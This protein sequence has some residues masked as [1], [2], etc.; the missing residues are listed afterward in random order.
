MSEL[1]QQFLQLVQERKALGQQRH[2][3]SYLTGPSL[4]PVMTEEAADA[5]NYAL[6][7][8]ARV[9]RVDPH[10]DFQGLSALAGALALFGERLTGTTAAATGR[11]EAFADLAA[12]RMKSPAAA[13]YRADAWKTRANLPEAVEELADLYVL[14][15][16][17]IALRHHRGERSQPLHLAI[18]RYGDLAGELAIAA[19]EITVPAVHE[20][21]A[22]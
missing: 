14:S 19:L 21:L 18:L 3:D 7:E 10:F 20:T 4:L 16:L 15:R 5:Y 6:M 9:S 22:A 8:I 11:I 12:K 13:E 17:E 1:Q 2:G